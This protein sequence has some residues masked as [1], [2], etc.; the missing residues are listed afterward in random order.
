MLEDKEMKYMYKNVKYSVKM[1]LISKNEDGSWTLENDTYKGLLYK[2]KN[3][4]E[5]LI[6]VE[7]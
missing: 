4:K 6:E 5:E 2:V 3:P 1:K 7:D